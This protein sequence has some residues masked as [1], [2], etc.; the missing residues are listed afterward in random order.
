MTTTMT[1]PRRMARALASGLSLLVAA[2]VGGDV[3]DDGGEAPPPIA[4]PVVAARTA[5]WAD[6]D[7][8]PY[9]PGAAASEARPRA[10]GLAPDG[11]SR[12][13][14]AEAL[15]PVLLR[16]DGL[17]MAREPNWAA[18]DAIRGAT[19]PSPAAAQSTAASPAERGAAGAGLEALPAE[20]HGIPEVIG[21]DG[22]TL[23]PDTTAAPFSAMARVVSTFDGGGGMR[24][25]GTYIGPFTVILAGHCLRQ[26]NGAVARR[27]LFEPGRKGDEF[28][29]WYFDCRNDDASTSN[30]FLAAIP[31][32]YASS[33][34]PAYDF[35]VIDTFPC[36]SAP[37]WLGQ[38][39][40]NQGIIVDAGDTTYS[41]HG[42]PGNPCPGAP[43]GSFYNCGMAG[44]AYRNG[45]WMESEYIDSEAGQS[46]GP[47]HIAGRV[48]ATHVG[49]RDYFDLFRCGFDLCRR[50]YGRRIDPAYKTFLDA[51]AFDYP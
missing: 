49:Y 2:C 13:E 9:E 6:L 34:D 16:P 30:D 48:V 42:Y 35:A 7:V 4:D 29:F 28:P 20:T 21:G 44:Y 22:R 39:A 40:H 1:M 33:Q 50:N 5:G 19:A 37:R 10:A 47:W 14:L 17:F 51:I 36:H 32:A 26:P 45:P 41:L 23:V 38:P 31:A 27:I 15:R 12:E 24:C 25:T 46:G 43:S 18:A 3:D 8:I 11:P